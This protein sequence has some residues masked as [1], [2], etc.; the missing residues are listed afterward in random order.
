VRRVLP[1][2]DT[3]V[4]RWVVHRELDTSQRVRVV[5]DLLV[6]ELA[7]PRRSAVEPG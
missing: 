6:T 2:L 7:S 5:F 1:A 3:L 4:L